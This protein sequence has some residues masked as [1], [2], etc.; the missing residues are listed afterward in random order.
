MASQVGREERG[1]KRRREGGRE[2]KGGANLFE[3]LL[4]THGQADHSLWGICLW[5]FLGRFL[6]CEKD[7]LLKYRS[8]GLLKPPGAKSQVRAG[9]CIIS[10]CHTPACALCPIE[11]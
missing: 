10:G 11:P 2:G 7:G 4:L 8:A 1:E 5:K 6:K 3:G 9:I